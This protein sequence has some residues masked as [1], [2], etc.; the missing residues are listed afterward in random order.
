MTLATTLKQKKKK[1]KKYIS[2]GPFRTLPTL[3][4][5]LRI[6]FNIFLIIHKYYRFPPNENRIFTRKVSYADEGKN[7]K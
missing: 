7:N 6:L 5:K 2:I 4:S 3:K 1:K